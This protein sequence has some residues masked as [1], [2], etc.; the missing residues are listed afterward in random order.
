MKKEPLNILVCGPSG[1]GKT[2]AACKIAE[3][4]GNRVVVLNAS[5]NE[6]A[7]LKDMERGNWDELPT[8]EDNVTYIIE[9]I[10]GL[11]QRQ[12][13]TLFHLTCYVSRHRS[14][15]II[16]I[17]Y[18][19]HC[20]GISSLLNFVTD[21]YFTNAKIN[22]RALKTCLSH[23]MYTDVEGA[24]KTFSKLTQGEYLHLEAQIGRYRR[25]TMGGASKSKQDDEEGG[26]GEPTHL[27]NLMIYFA[28]REDAEEFRT[29]L[30]FLLANIEAKLIDKKDWSVT[31]S[32][33]AGEKMKLSLLDYVEALRGTARPSQE[34]IAL[35]SLLC[36]SCCLPQMLV[37]NELLNELGKKRKK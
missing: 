4:T 21:V 6:Y 23:Y 3:A 32:T 20:T 24:E 31:A 14:C 9:D 5:P 25:V 22:L 8:E 30:R 7:E 29:L 2:Y 35:H 36:K 34:T 10:A 19:L 18:Q 28:H 1:S 17:T 12:R 16:L 27:E 11:T 15:P 37:K 26:E 13:K 33:K